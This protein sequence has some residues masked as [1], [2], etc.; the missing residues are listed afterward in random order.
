M[1]ALQGVSASRLDGVTQLFELDRQQRQLLADVVVQFARDARPLGF[2]RGD[3]PA[4]EI[5][6]PGVAA[7]K[8][9]LALE[10]ALFGLTALSS[11]HEQTGDEHRLYEQHRDCANDVELVALP[12]GRLSKLDQWFRPGREPR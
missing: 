11:M 8:L 6:D 2:L 3:Q 9:R 10:D 1:G 7:A 4:G 12:G 5:A